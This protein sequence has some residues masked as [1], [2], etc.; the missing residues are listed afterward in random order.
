[1]IRLIVAAVLYASL[2][3]SAFAQTTLTVY[4]TAESDLIPAYTQAIKKEFPD[5]ELKWVR[6]STG[7]MTARLLAEKDAPKADLIFGLAVTSMKQ[8]QEANIIVP[9]PVTAPDGSVTMKQWIPYSIWAN[10]VTYN[11]YELEALNLPVPTSWEDLTKPVYKGHIVMPYPFSSG[12][13]FMQV[14][15]WLKMFGEK[16]GWEY[17]DKLHKNIKFYTH[18]G[19]KPC[20]LSAQGEIALGISSGSFADILQRQGA[21]LSIVYPTPGIGWDTDIAASVAGSKHP[22]L[23]QKIVAFAASDA[24]ANIVGTSSRITPNGKFLNAETTKQRN[25]LLEGL[26]EYM[27]ENKPAIMTEWKKRYEGTN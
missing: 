22:E 5:V 14:A 13:G 11:T 20:A 12:T 17:M 21:P 1:M 9:T 7:I 16:K 10:A 8:L 25:Q 24:I 4:S 18:S 26:T 23:A 2:I 3:G 6:D 19:T 27:I 15:A